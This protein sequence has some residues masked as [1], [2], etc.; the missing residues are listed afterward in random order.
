MKIG[1]NLTSPKS[2]SIASKLL[3]MKVIDF[4]E[5]LLDNFIFCDPYMIRDKFGDIP[6]S[7]HIMFSKF[8]E[9][10]S[11]DLEAL[12]VR[13]KHWIHVLKPIYISDHIAKFSVDGRSLIFLGEVNYKKEFTKVKDY[14]QAWQDL[15]GEKIYFENFPSFI[16]YDAEQIDFL[17]RLKSETGCGILFDLSNA[18]IASKNSQYA[19]SQWL[20]MAS[21]SK[22]F[23]IAGY[24]E[25]DTEPKLW[26]DSHDC[27]IS[28][29]TI[30]FFGE[31]LKYSGSC[32]DKSIIIERDSKIELN[33]LLL[34]IAKVR[35]EIYQMDGLYV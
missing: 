26:M 6:V 21:D 31:F 13:I 1:I 5:L 2:V 7:F 33:S 25:S 15:L 22:H 16:D 18:V 34:D 23:H 10:N 11:K 20:S 12:S 17:D 3:E 27:S 4:Y 24:C 14:V 32:V 9:R 28:P 35:G 19:L 29:E 8:M 30:D